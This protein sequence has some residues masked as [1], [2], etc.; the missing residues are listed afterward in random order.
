MS[1]MSL[2]TMRKHRQRYLDYDCE[3]ISTAAEDDLLEWV[4]LVAGVHLGGDVPANAQGEAGYDCEQQ[5]IRDDG[6]HRAA[7]Q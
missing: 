1:R 3:F 5:D 6:E 7:R 4:H 2:E